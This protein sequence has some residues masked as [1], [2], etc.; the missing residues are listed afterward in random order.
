MG[1]ALFVPSDLGVPCEDRLTISFQMVQGYRYRKGNWHKW[2]RLLFTFSLVFGT[3][4]ILCFQIVI[5][6][7]M[8]QIMHFLFKEG[9]S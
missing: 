9:Y 1:Y 6:V 5:E 7:F 4:A 2:Y 8:D 3:S